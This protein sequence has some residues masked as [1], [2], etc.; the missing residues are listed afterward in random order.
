MIVS[1]EAKSSPATS[2]HPVDTTSLRSCVYPCV[3]ML[4]H[5]VN[6]IVIGSVLIVFVKLSLLCDDHVMTAGV[7][8]DKMHHLS[9]RRWNV[10]T[11]TM[12]VLGAAQAQ[13]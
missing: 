10:C 4:I 12:V 3:Q 1:A 13:L 8:S 9:K 11:G 5:E 6:L 2:C 7:R